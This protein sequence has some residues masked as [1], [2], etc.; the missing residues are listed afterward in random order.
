MWFNIIRKLVSC[1]RFF[2]QCHFPQTFLQ[3][4]L[5]LLIIRGNLVTSKSDLLPFSL[6]KMQFQ[7]KK[8]AIPFY[9]PSLLKTHILLSFS[10][11][12]LTLLVSINTSDNF[13]KVFAFLENISRWHQTFTNSQRYLQFLCKRKPV[14]SN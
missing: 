7:K 1:T 8:N 13:L 12:E 10:N 6:I 9:M 14:F 5:I 3:S 11:H 4:S 2:P